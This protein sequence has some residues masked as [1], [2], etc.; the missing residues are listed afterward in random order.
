MLE[1]M[2]IDA[3]LAQSPV[4]DPDGGAHTL[5]EAWR[6]RPAL[7]TFLRHYG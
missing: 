5:M 6:D 2:R 7:L 3:A 4:Y 1:P